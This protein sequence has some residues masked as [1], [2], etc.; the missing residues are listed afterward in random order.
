M[1]IINGQTILLR[2]LGQCLECRTVLELLQISTEAYTT[3]KTFSNGNTDN[4]WNHS[5][6]KALVVTIQKT[7]IPYVDY[8]E[9]DKSS[10]VSHLMTLLLHPKSKK[11]VHWPK[12]RL[13]EQ[14]I[15]VSWFLQ[16]KQMWKACQEFRNMEIKECSWPKEKQKNYTSS[17]K[18][19]TLPFWGMRWRGMD[20]MQLHVCNDLILSCSLPFCGVSTLQ[21]EVLQT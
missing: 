16:G 13:R 15:K 2:S 17:N 20:R 4:E 1:F 8:N 10:L 9:F 18:N 11:W 3:N 7:L 12:V 19:S 6:E 14:A 21:Y 5:Q